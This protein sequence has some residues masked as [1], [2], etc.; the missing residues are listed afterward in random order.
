MADH[1]VSQLSKIGWLNIL[2]AGSTY[3][4]TYDSLSYKARV[5]KHSLQDE[6][7]YVDF[8]SGL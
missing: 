1:K 5:P 6:P 8:T 4:H 2:L 3:S 7:T